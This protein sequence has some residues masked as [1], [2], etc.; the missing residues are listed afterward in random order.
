MRKLLEKESTRS[1]L[2]GIATT[3]G[4][5]G[6]VKIG[7][8]VFV[9]NVLLIIA[10][11][12]I[13][14]SSKVRKN[15]TRRMRM[16]VGGAIILLFL[17]IGLYHATNYH[18][19]EAPKN[20][21]EVVDTTKDEI[22]AQEEKK[23]VEDKIEAPKTESSKAKGEDKS[24]TVSFDKNGYAVQDLKDDATFNNLKN[25][26][27]SKESTSVEGPKDETF[28]S[29]KKKESE[30]DIVFSQPEEKSSKTSEEELAEEAFKEESKSKQAVKSEATIKDST[31]KAESNSSNSTSKKEYSQKPI[32]VDALDS[33]SAYVGESIQ[34]KIEGEN[35]QFE[36]LEG[37]EYSFSKGILT[38]E[39]G[40][41][42]TVLTVRVFNDS[43]S[44]DFNVYINGLK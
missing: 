37:I 3:L 26:D 41:Y 16:I 8:G 5:Y 22:T 20:E 33:Y 24:G 39:C 34:F 44:V 43:N 23:D 17:G 29:S 28:E 1:Y 21:S 19:L 18:V 31:K 14:N 2:L 27:G 13:I 40:E 32:R 9:L 42:A 25:E 6:L 12:A 11:I 30:K 38:I 10:T 36:G 7:C 15:F 4:V 35:V